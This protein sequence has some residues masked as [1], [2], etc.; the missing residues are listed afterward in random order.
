MIYGK[1][2]EAECSRLMLHLH[3]RE[4]L[5]V[6]T[7]RVRRVWHTMNFLIVTNTFKLSLSYFSKSFPDSPKQVTNPFSAPPLPLRT[8]IPVIIS[9]YFHSHLTFV[10]LLNYHLM[11]GRNLI[12]S[13]KS[14]TAPAR[15]K[16]FVTLC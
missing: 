7:L 3:E 2:E 1:R 13:I 6:Q 14:S 15:S 5:S 8:S 9:V 12:L 11:E 16:H 10:S 4:V